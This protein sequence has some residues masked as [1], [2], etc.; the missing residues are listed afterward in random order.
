MQRCTDVVFTTIMI[1]CEGNL[2]SKVEASLIQ[3]CEFD[4]V[5]STLQERC[6]FDFVISM[7]KHRCQYHIHSTSLVNIT[8]QL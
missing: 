1:Y 5:V 8:I 3:H 6:E 4:V 7:F 2:L